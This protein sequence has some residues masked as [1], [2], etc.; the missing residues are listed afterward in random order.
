[1]KELVRMVLHTSAIATS[2]GVLES[3][4]INT[5]AVPMVLCWAVVILIDIFVD[6]Q[7]R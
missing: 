6:R 1:M 4:G 3:F 2:Y 5:I 7:L